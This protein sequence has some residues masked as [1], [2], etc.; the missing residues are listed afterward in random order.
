MSVE[1]TEK[2]AAT[3]GGQEGGPVRDFLAEAVARAG[4]PPEAIESLTF[5]LEGQLR[6][7]QYTR[8]DQVRQGDEG[9]IPLARVFVDLASRGYYWLAYSWSSYV[10]SCERC[11][12][13]CKRSYFPLTPSPDR[14]LP[15][16]PGDE[17]Q[18]RSLLINP[19][20]GPDPVEHLEFKASGLVDPR[21][22]SRHGFETIRT[23]GLYRPSLVNVR[24]PIATRAHDLIQRIVSAISAR[25]EE[26]K[27]EAMR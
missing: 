24:A 5:W 2:E 9:G 18:E 15:P 7:D 14:R 21:G 13:A 4:L 17:A 12:T 25:D 26:R 1:E 22:E 20:D 10:L 11:N 19:F 3:G 23:Y 27:D 16:A 6:E 8:L